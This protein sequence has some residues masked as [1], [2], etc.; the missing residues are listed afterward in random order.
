MGK[1]KIGM[2]CYFIADILTKVFFKKCLMSGLLP[3]IYFKSKPRDLI[4]CHGNQKAEFGK[5]I[6]INSSEAI[7]GIKLKLFR[8][9]HSISLYKSIAFHCCCICTLIAMA[10]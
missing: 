3:N 7:W 9:V 10:T 8:N 6:K 1:K 5:N 2:Y 4:G